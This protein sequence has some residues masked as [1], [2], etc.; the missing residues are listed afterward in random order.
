MRMGGS[1]LIRGTRLST[2]R[3]NHD[4]RLRRVNLTILNLNSLRDFINEFRVSEQ[5]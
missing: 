2:C 1:A 3:Q 4:K 5:A